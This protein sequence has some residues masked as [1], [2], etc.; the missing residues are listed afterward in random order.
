MIFVRVYDSQ[1]IPTR[2]MTLQKQGDF[3]SHAQYGDFTQ[4][5]YRPELGTRYV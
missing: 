2:H 4:I 5:G 1:R 3:H